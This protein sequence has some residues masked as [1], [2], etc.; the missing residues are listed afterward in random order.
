MATAGKTRPEY[1]GRT[2]YDDRYLNK[3]EGRRA[4]EN[5]I[6][7]D[8]L[9]T[10]EVRGRLLDAPCGVARVG[11][12]I[13]DRPVDYTAGDISSSMVESASNRLSNLTDSGLSYRL[14]RC[15]LEAMPFAGAS[16]DVSLCLRLLH[17]LPRPIRARVVAEIARLT[18]CIL[19]V[20]YFHLFALHFLERRLKAIIKRQP[21]Y[22]Y[23][24]IAGWLKSVLEPHGFRM[25]DSRGTG[26]LRETRYAVFERI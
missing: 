3:A 10:H 8:L 16:F 17:H 12:L 25:V 9:D 20:T 5:A 7:L 4:R 21:S 24:N 18:E 19:M 13:A 15:D 23:S 11:A 22:R 1:S 26:F 14:M 2:K 6:L